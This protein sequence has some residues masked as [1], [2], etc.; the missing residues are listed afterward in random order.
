MMGT[1][2]AVLFLG[3]LPPDRKISEP[4]ENQGKNCFHFL[5]SL[6]ARRGI[7]LTVEERKHNFSLML[8]TGV[9]TWI[10]FVT[11]SIPF[12]PSGGH[13]PAILVTGCFCPI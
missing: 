12:L 3:A 8:E 11:S 1:P 9:T 6:K 2:L 5:V 7:I 10:T 4:R 13:G